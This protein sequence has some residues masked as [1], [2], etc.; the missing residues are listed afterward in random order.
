MVRN[1]FCEDLFFCWSLRRINWIVGVPCDMTEGNLIQTVWIGRVWKK[2]QWRV[3]DDKPCIKSLVVGSYLVRNDSSS[4]FFAQTKSNYFL[5]SIKNKI[6]WSLFTGML[7]Y[8]D[9]KLWVL[10]V[11][12]LWKLGQMYAC[13]NVYMVGMKALLSGL[14][15]QLFEVEN[16][17]SLWLTASTKRTQRFTT[18]YESKERYDLYEKE[19]LYYRK[20]PRKWLKG[21]KIENYVMILITG[22]QRC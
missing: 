18:R 2:G 15:R 3:V 16:F 7:D 1:H 5:T 14:I 9:L 6:L 21:A 10:L 4:H 22:I 19:P 11:T 20:Q 8:Y 13:V 17:L 12:L